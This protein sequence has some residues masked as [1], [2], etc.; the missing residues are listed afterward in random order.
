MRMQISFLKMPLHENL[1]GPLITECP[2]RAR[3]EFIHRN[4]RYFK[5]SFRIVTVKALFIQF[6]FSF[7]FKPLI[8]C[9]WFAKCAIFTS[10]L[11][12]NILVALVLHY[13]WSAYP[14]LRVLCRFHASRSRGL[15]LVS[16]MSRPHWKAPF[17]NRQRR[18]MAVA[19]RSWRCRWRETETPNAGTARGVERLHRCVET[20]VYNVMLT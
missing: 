13:N 15:L 1:L 6:D 7:C 19:M 3:A 8:Q 14:Q 10:I 16:G 9:N 4:T 11:E 5:N 17:P 2:E 18:C 12:V 20:K